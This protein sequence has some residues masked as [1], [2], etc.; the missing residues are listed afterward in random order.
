MGRRKWKLYQESMSRNYLQPLNNNIKRTNLSEDE[1]EYQKEVKTQS[2][3]LDTE[4]EDES[5]TIKQETNGDCGGDEEDSPAA[6]AAAA[7]ETQETKE[8]ECQKENEKA[9]LERLQDW[10]PETKCYFCVDGKLDSEHTA[11]GVL[12]P[13]P[14]E[15]DTSDSHSDSEVPTSLT[16]TSRGL[17]NNNH[18]NL[19]P[20]QHQLQL[21]HLG[22]QGGAATATASAAAAA[23][24]AAAHAAM[25]TIENVSMAALAVAALSGAAH[26]AAHAASNGPPT[27]AQQSPAAASSPA[28]PPNAAAGV[29]QPPTHLPFY[30]PAAAAAN[31]LTHNWY[32]ANVARSFQSVTGNGSTGSGTAS[33][34]D[35]GGGGGGISGTAG[36]QPLDLSKG[37]AAS[38]NS[39]AT[40]NA[41]HQDKISS[42]L[43][44]NLP[45]LPTLDTKHIFKA[46]PRVSAVAGRRTYTEDEL[47]AALRDI[48]STL[49]NKVY[50]LALEKERESHL[51]S[52]TLKLDEEEAMDDDKELSGTEEEKEVEKTLESREPPT[53]C[54]ICWRWPPTIQTSRLIC[55]LRRSG[56]WQ[57]P[58]QP[59]PPP[60]TCPPQPPG[61]SCRTSSDGWRHSRQKTLERTMENRKRLLSL[62]DHH[63]ATR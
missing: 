49:R 8:E 36:E 63:L 51:N 16:S 60:P 21:Q 50:K 48:Q 20:G 32:L 61:C 12:S 22:A 41:Q 24:A 40:S 55:C 11:H 58:Q 6:A 27:T 26:A 34:V 33:E 7:S 19:R 31:V 44:N 35:K 30:G 25:T 38:G 47:Q 39:P 52:S 17:L 14:Y 62:V 43:G 2:V 54:A 45:R 29:A 3:V 15:S 42:P 4:K 10:T 37:S 46:K 59:A 18:H 23:A 13:R 1:E 57:P 5:T 56:C 28:L 53:L 9:A